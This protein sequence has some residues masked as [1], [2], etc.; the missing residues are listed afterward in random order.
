MRQR[1]LI[2][3]IAEV[4]LV[5]LHPK[6]GVIEMQLRPVTPSLPAR[7][8]NRRRDEFTAII[9]AS[10]RTSHGKV[11]GLRSCFRRG[12]F[13]MERELRVPYLHRATSGY[14]GPLRTAKLTIQRSSELAYLLLGGR[15]G[16]RLACAGVAHVVNGSAD[17]FAAS[18]RCDPRSLMTKVRYG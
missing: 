6:D 13:C 2:P 14:G 5:C 7:R 8:A 11:Y 12:S 1:T 18:T 17:R 16:A 9:G 15:A 10:W 3:D 4:E